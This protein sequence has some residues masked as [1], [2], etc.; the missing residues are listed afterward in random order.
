[1]FD[2]SQEANFMAVTPMA[3]ITAAGALLAFGL[4]LAGCSN[5]EV[6]LAPPQSGLGCV[7]DSPHCIAER[8]NAL[9][10]L[11]GDKSKA[12]VRAPASPAA[13]A[14]GVRLWAFKQKKRELNCDELSHA[15]READAAA[16]TL[17]SANGSLTPAQISRG[18]MLAQ[19]VSKELGNEFGRRCRA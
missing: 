5:N 6:A 8:G 11:M 14:S 9:K 19:D 17:R 13:Y 10:G 7:D 12:W 2:S 18:I 16:P 4:I 3:R 1:M 15:R